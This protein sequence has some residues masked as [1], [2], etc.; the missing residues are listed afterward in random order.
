MDNRTYI[1]I[2][3]KSFYASVECVDRGLNPLTTNLVVAD[4]S[5][6]EKTICLAVTPSLKSFGV[7]S[8]PRL[9]EV[10][11]KV[12][13]I[14]NNRLRKCS[15]HQFSGE[16][17]NAIELNNNPSLKLTYIVASPK[18]AHYIEVSSKIYS[19]YLKYIA[20]EDIHVYSIDEVFMDVSK[21]LKTYKMNAH[22]LAM[23]IIKDVLKETGIT[24]TAGIGTNMYLAKVA[25]D[26]VAKKMKPDKDGV[27]IAELNE[28]SYRKELWNYRPL[29][30]FW[31]VGPG[32]VKR[33]EKLG[34]FT[35]GDIAKCSTGTFN[36]YY[37]EDLL[38]KEFGINAELLI[39]HAWGI[40][41]TTIEDVKKYKPK[42]N[43]L[44]TGQV[45]LCGYS[46]IKTQ[47]IVKE[48]TELLSLDLVE[49]G[50]LTSQLTLSIGYDA[51]S[52][53]NIH[54]YDGL[55]ELDHYGRS[56][57]KGVHSSIN[58]DGYTS[59]TRELMEAIVKL[60]KQI[61]N[62]NLLIRR[63][64]ICASKLV[65]ACDANHYPQIK[66]FCLFE[67]SAIIINQEHEKQ[68]MRENENKLQKTIIKI[69]NKYGK[70]A[71]VKGMNLEEGGTTIERNEQ[72]GGHKS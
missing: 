30:D 33:L 8:R 43:S 11:Q 55:V 38:Y 48:M 20:V 14:N 23:T 22:E 3:L 58:L 6:T 39:D 57:P 59:S 64:V 47:L 26:I 71:I 61:V 36:D 40:E 15:N 50:L 21:Y 52:L 25:M 10:I 51:E 4:A 65:K 46:F 70:N 16:S 24:A 60:Y 18:M 62:P 13:E 68:K 41:P 54:N 53:I 34:L 19:I 5:R 72:I 28:M 29:I 31:R 49:K 37:N 42:S 7:S 1:C 27:R 44:S 63:I 67:N 17:D 66:Q 32:Y 69:K 9:F 2:D 35:M 12:K 45:L 56:I